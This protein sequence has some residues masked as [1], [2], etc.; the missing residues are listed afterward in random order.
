MVAAALLELVVLPAALAV[1][2]VLVAPALLV[3][4]AEGLFTVGAQAGLDLCALFAGALALLLALQLE[5]RLRL[6]VKC[7]PLDVVGA[8]AERAA[9]ALVLGLLGGCELVALVRLDGGALAGGGCGLL[10][11][12]ALAEGG[13]LGVDVVLGDAVVLE[14]DLELEALRLD[15]ALALV[16]E[17]ALVGGAVG[18]RLL[19]VGRGVAG[20]LAGADAVRAEG[21][22]CTLAQSQAALVRA[23]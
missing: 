8:D 20:L 4:F 6:A 16:V 14:L 21:S 15:L 19:E 18:E 13:D 17:D 23:H 9:H 11:G 5:L 22:V 1:H 12:E 2:V 3:A 10:S 7:E